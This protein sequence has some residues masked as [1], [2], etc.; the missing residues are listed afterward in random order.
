MKIIFL[1]IIATNN[2]SEQKY[3]RPQT[4]RRGDLSELKAIKTIYESYR[5]LFYSL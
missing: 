4:L 2:S 1:A 3:T 5:Q